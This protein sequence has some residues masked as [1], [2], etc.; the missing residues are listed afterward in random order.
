MERRVFVLAPSGKDAALIG[1]A[2]ERSQIQV[3]V[4]TRAHEVV[5]QA[6]AGIGALMVAEEALKDAASLLLL[7]QMV[8]AQP[9]WSD[10]PVLLL[11]KRGRMSPLAAGAVLRLGNVT[12]IERP[13]QVS[14][15]VSTVRT[16]LRTR[17][18]QYEMRQADVRKDM[19]L[20]TL[21]HE[22]RNPLAPLSN[23]LHLLQAAGMAA[24]PQQRWA[25][26]VM[27]RQTNQLTRLVDDLLDVARITQGKITLQKE[28]LDL[29]DA[30]HAAIETSM[31]QI[32]AMEHAFA[33]HL[34]PEPVW[35]QAD[36]TRVAQCVSNLLTNAAKYTPRRGRIAVM[37]RT[38]E[39][40]AE[41]SVRDNGIGFAQAEAPRLFEVFAQVEEAVPRAQGGLGL[42]LSIVKALTEMHGGAVS[43]RSEGPGQGADFSLR[44][45]LALAPADAAA[46]RAP[47]RREPGSC[48]RVLVV[49]DNR[50]SADSMGE[51]LTSCGHQTRVAYS[52]AEALQVLA[53]WTPQVALLDIGLPDMTGHDLAQRIRANGPDTVPV[54]VAL[55]GWGQATDMER[56]REAGFAHH[57]TKPADIGALLALVDEVSRSI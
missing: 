3:K 35:A 50:D 57:L 12:V 18:R 23:A 21:A 13:T 8:E 32:E 44:L 29:R 37:M 33:V 43:A 28:H 47:Q 5:E 45:P 7:H 48:C 16:A 51:L 10:L 14:T 38:H 36:R 4:C 52:G 1:S 39:G 26:G 15:L 53:D 25:V 24:Q 41:I 9:S 17:E 40:H 54:L 46:A 55:T 49:D 27:Q 2:L 22:L 31:P 56:S 20:A 11:T 42:G 19:F 6:R 30:V 34:P